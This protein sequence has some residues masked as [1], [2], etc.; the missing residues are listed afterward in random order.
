MPFE[1]GQGGRPR[2][3]FNASTR[4]AKELS[5]KLGIDPIHILLLFAAGDWE[6]LGYNGKYETKGYT[7]QGQEIMGLTIEPTVR[8]KAAAEVAQYIAPKL[9]A[10]E[11]TLP[12]MLEGKTNQEKLSLAKDLV[13]ELEYKVEE[14]LKKN[15]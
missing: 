13:K 12:N 10:I 4:R 1:P 9:K 3:A 11:Y 5:E 15:E 7:K 6:S 14:E 8:C 2:G